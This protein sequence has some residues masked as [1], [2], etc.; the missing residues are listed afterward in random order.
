MKQ[1][2]RASLAVLMFAGVYAGIATP[3]P[4][5]TNPRNAITVSDTGGSPTPTTPTYPGTSPTSPTNPKSN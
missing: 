4:A 1:L 2:L 5:L 3:A